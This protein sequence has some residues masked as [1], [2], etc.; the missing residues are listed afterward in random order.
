[1]NPLLRKLG[2]DLVRLQGQVITIAL[3]VACG[4]ASFVTLRSTYDSLIHSRDAYYEAF[5]FGDVF[6]RL[7]RAPRSI[8]HDL[9][10]VDGVAQVYT[11]VVESAMLPMPDMPRPATG[12][13]VSLPEHDE[14]PLNAVYIRKGRTLE[15]GRAD[16]VVILEAFARAHALEPGDSVPAVINGTLR[17]LRI[18][19]IGMSPEFVMTIPQGA[20][21]FDPKRI[22]VLWM[23]RDVVA[24][25]YQKE[26]AFNDVVARLQPGADEVAVLDAIDDVLAPYGG[27]GAVPR[28]KQSSHYILTGEISQLESMATVVPFIFL[29]VAAFLLNVVL[30]RLVTLQRSQIATLKAVGY[31]DRDV[32]LHYLQLVSLV[33]LLGAAIGTAVGVYLGDAMLGMYTGEYFRFPQPA[34]RLELDV[35]V[36]GVLVSLGAAVVGAVGATGRVSRMPPAEAMRPPAPANYRKTLLERIGVFRWL[37]PASRMILRELQRR[38]MRLLLSAVGIALSIGIVVTSRYMYDA[39]NHMLDVQVHR[40]MR[41]D[42]TVVLAKPLPQRAVRALEKLPG[43]FRA[44]GQRTVAVRFHAGHRHRDAVIFGHPA[45]GELRRVVDGAGVSAVVPSQ[46]GILLTTKLGELLDLSLGATISVELRE[47]DRHVHE[48]V[49]AGFVDESFGLQGH[50]AKDALHRVL[51]EEETVNTVLLRVDTERFD[52]ITY[53]LKELPWGVERVFTS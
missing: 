29:F 27:V 7:E 28:A 10:S 6:A 49:V 14:P 4:I 51:G 42:I 17:E 48:L 24:S 5:R 9:E 41:E 1:M 13:V 44:E 23:N 19:G 31:R 36:T 15:P 18:V 2:R 22:A 52:A 38:P 39:T 11:R 43:V 33:V 45:G 26:G 32:A 20:M 16:E 34:Y 21:T 30:S 53:E 50:M 3:V 25:A 35:A 40:A 12:I 46:G 8:T 47:G 37:G